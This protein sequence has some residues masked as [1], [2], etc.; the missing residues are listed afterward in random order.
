MMELL[1]LVRDIVCP[2]DILQD[3]WYLDLVLDDV[4]EPEPG[5][6]VDSYGR[7]LSK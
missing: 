6:A 1:T 4:N 7:F 5:V 3:D 2:G